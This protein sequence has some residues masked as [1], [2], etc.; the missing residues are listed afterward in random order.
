MATLDF[1]AELQEK[2]NKFHG[3]D[4]I[5][6]MTLLTNAGY[7][8][9][10][11]SIMFT[12]HLRQFKNLID[13]DI[14]RVFTNY[15]NAVGDLSTGYYKAKKKV[16]IIDKVSRFENGKDDDHL[17]MLF[18]YDK[19]TDTY[20][21]I[22]KKLVEDLTEKFGYGYITDV[23]DSK[24]VGDNIDKD[25][26]LFRSTS[27][28]DQMNYGY[29]RNVK[30]M[31]AMENHTIE[32]AIVCSKSFANSM[33]SKEVE[34]V[35]VALNDN[36]ILCNIFGDNDIYK[37]FVDIGETVDDKVICARRRIHNNQILYDMK[38][39]NLR[40]ININN[41][42]LFY[43][44]NGSRLV[45]ITIYSNKKLD[46]IPDNVFNKQI[47]YYLKMQENFYKK[48][49]DRC[50]KIIK[51][52]SN[53]TS[54]ISFFYKKA[55]DILDPNVLYREENSSAFSNIIIEFLFERDTRLTIGQ[56]IRQSLVI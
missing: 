2:E 45:D 23:M 18:T 49:Y 22:E 50:K 24:S 19:E 26:V 37:C 5:F 39:S 42:N 43:I 13:S 41:D 48:I 54:D 38:K 3:K 6:G 51:S 32:D 46:D 44:E 29:G 40:K 10:M 4:D 17:Y 8:S 14:P 15:E 11:R 30:V 12:S 16:E 9:S 55:K 31:Y 36:D 47:R 21:I 27:Y 1:K 35:K 20:G 52:G 7:I 33:V 34:T 56:K 25:E 28:D 53:F